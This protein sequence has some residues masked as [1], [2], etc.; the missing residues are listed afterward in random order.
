VGL[1]QQASIV[2]VVRDVR[3]TDGLLGDGR[4]AVRHAD[5]ADDRTGPKGLKSPPPEP[6]HAYHGN[7]KGLFGLILGH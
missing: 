1:G 2:A 3:A 6:A 7:R 5:H 4:V